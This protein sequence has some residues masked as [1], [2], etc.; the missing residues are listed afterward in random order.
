VRVCEGSGGVM[1][2]VEEL[3]GA[4]FVDAIAGMIWNIGTCMILDFRKRRTDCVWK[5]SEVNRCGFAGVRVDANCKSPSSTA[6]SANTCRIKHRRIEPRRDM[7]RPLC[8][9]E[10]EL[11]M[12]GEVTLKLSL[13]GR[14]KVD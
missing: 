13:D 9:A 14:G 11:Q 5:L 4:G 1:E 7:A 12:Y 6:W 2:R 10:I 3:V 8:P